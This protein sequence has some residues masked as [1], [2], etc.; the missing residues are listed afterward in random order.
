MLILS[1]TALFELHQSQKHKLLN[2]EW[3]E[4][5]AFEN[6]DK[7][8]VSFRCR[9]SLWTCLIHFCSSI[10]PCM[11][12]VEKKRLLPLL[13]S[14][15]HLDIAIFMS[16]NCGFSWILFHGTNFLNTY[17]LETFVIWIGMMQQHRLS[18][19]LNKQSFCY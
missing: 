12:S 10:F 3:Y 7:T 14:S 6:L 16:F 11:T 4:I 5:L 13:R 18:L 15:F 2:C 19:S 9:Y 8:T 1:F 17:S